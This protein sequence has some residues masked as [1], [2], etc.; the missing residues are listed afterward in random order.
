MNP[1]KLKM[2]LQQ[3]FNEDLGERDITSETIFSIDEK[4]TG[5]FLIKKDGVIAGL[6]IIREAYSLFDPSIEVNFHAKDGDLVKAG[7][8][9]ATV[10]GPIAYLLSGERVILNLLQRMSGIATMTRMA[11]DKL[12]S[13]H[14]RVC[15]TRKTTPGLR[16]LEKYAV[17]C[18]GGFNHRFGLYDAVM[19]KDNH[20][21]YAGSITKAV[22]LVKK[23]LGHM[24]KIEVETESKEDV[25]EAVKAGADVILFDNC[26]PEEV[27]EYVSLVPDSI[28]TEASGGI[29]FENIANYGDTGVDYISL[30]MLTHSVHALDISFNISGGKKYETVGSER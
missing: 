26:S 14:T 13:S 20:I 27:K 17:R 21:A 3:L 2:L 25:I 6:P 24:T 4:T 19:I 22:E 10:N 11:V 1:I 9:V 18:G 8:I 5:Q 28:I 30:G 16:M 23:Q 15:D 7:D 12:N 29:T